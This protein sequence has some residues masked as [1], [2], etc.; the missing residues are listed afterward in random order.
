[1]SHSQLD[2]A[3]INKATSWMLHALKIVLG[4]QS[5][6]RYI[7]L[8]YYPT[9]VNKSKKCIR[10]FDA[11]VAKGTTREDKANNIRKYC[12]KMCSKPEFVVFTASNIQR[13]RYDN[14]THFQSYIIDNTLK[15]L[16]VIDPAYNSQAENG[17][18]IYEAE[19]SHSI[20]IPFFH[21]KKYIVQFVSLSTPAQLDTGDVF[22][23]SWSLYLLIVMMRDSQ[24][25]RNL[26]VE[27]PLT[28]LDKYD[29]L[30]AFYRQIFT[31]MPELQDNLRVEYEGEILES[32]GPNRLTKLEKEELLS[33]DAVELLM[34]LTKYEMKQ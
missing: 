7:I 22:C 8:Y 30:L 9:L 31:D 1:M 32:R 12:S 19:I 25:Q 11:F 15:Q 27:I 28:Q 18:G 13:N 34:I 5:I 29:M 4:D 21:R 2:T 24:Y 10:T 16:I 14:E 20:I 17:T 26:T 6:R 23:Q 33:V 3:R